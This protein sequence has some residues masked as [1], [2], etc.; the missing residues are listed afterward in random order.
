MNLN[1][2]CCTGITWILNICNG[3]ISTTALPNDYIIFIDDGKLYWVFINTCF[4]TNIWRKIET[5]INRWINFVNNSIQGTSIVVGS[6][7][8]TNATVSGN[9][10]LNSDRG[11]N[12][13]STMQE[14]SIIEFSNNI[15]ETNT[16]GGGFIAYNRSGT[17]IAGA[18]NVFKVENNMITQFK[19]INI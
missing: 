17:S 9:R 15:L 16:G 10:I 3:I 13:T 5:R 7:R 14:G 2:K 8:L 6:N 4:T 11:I 18:V 19:F 12:V 1:G